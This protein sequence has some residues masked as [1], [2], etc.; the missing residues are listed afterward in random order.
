M[1]GPASVPCHRASR[2]TQ[3]SA[4]MEKN[5][6]LRICTSTLS[7]TRGTVSVKQPRTCHRLWTPPPTLSLSLRLLITA[8]A[9]VG[10]LPLLSSAGRA[11]TVTLAGVPLSRRIPVDAESGS[12][13]LP[14]HSFIH[15]TD[16]LPSNP[17]GGGSGGGGGGG[18]GGVGGDGG[19]GGGGA[20]KRDVGVDAESVGDTRSSATSR[21]TS[22]AAED[23]AVDNTDATT[24]A[25][26]SDSM[27][28]DGL[29]NVDL[30]AFPDFAKASVMAQ[31]VDVTA[32]DTLYIPSVRAL[33]QLPF[34]VYSA[35]STRV[36]FSFNRNRKHVLY[37][38]SCIG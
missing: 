8:A 6:S 31:R 36:V 7:S 10:Q 4:S 34:N 35:L 17:R 14:T 24:G 2:A 33:H 1:V 11:S 23:E 19:D 32:G 27:R 29:P 20:S 37:T 15:A 12:P 28:D 38:F 22:G 16:I 26:S 5:M 3:P 30:S 18:G 21:G 9:S 25:G 13:I